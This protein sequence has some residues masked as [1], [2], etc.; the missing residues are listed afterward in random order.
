[1]LVSSIDAVDKAYN[2]VGSQFHLHQWHQ[3][4]KLQRDYP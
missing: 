4:R 3:S 1:M 2:A